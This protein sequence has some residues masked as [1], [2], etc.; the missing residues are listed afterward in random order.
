MLATLEIINSSKNKISAKKDAK[1][2]F[3]IQAMASGNAWKTKINN[4]F[5]IKY[6]Q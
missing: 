6:I 2:K 1:N 3:N 4:G 5:R